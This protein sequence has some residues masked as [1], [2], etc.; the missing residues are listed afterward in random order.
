[1]K[2]DFIKDKLDSSKKISVI[3]AAKIMVYQLIDR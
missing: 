3:I 2:V 1:M